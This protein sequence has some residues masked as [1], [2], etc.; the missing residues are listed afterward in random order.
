MSLFHPANSGAEYYNYKGFYSLVM[1]ALVD[2]DYKFTFINVGCQ[3]RISDGGVYNNSAIENG[4][5]NLPDSCELPIIDT[6]WSDEIDEMKIP[7]LFVADD[8]F[9]LSTL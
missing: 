9:A 6:A 8:A 5:L 4:T 2:F 3:G 1:L 7:F